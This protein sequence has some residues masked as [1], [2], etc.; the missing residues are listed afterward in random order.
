MKY[1]IY[2]RGITLIELII[3]MSVVVILLTFVT[4]DILGSQRKASVTSSSILLVT[5]LRAQQ[6]KAMVG[7]NGGASIA[8]PSGIYFSGGSSYTLFSGVTYKPA[9]VNNFTI[10]LDS[11]I[12][13]ISSFSGSVIYFASGSG[14]ISGFTL[15]SDT[16]TLKN[17]FSGD[18]KTIKL[19]RYGVVTNV[20]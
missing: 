15:G 5:D 14:E 8:S 1:K 17:S 6:L 3:V 16:L 4:I 7:E 19:N 20:N 12:Q 10:N 9:D 2:S 11:N 13:L 18:K